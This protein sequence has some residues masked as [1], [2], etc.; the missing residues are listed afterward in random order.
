MSCSIPPTHDLSC[1]DASPERVFALAGNP[2]FETTNLLGKGEFDIGAA[3][4]LDGGSCNLPTID[5]KD[6]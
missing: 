6:F 4:P 5:V 1:Q 2:Y 3:L